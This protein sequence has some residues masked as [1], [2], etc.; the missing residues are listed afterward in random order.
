MWKGEKKKFFPPFY[1][2]PNMVIVST[3]TTH[4]RMMITNDKPTTQ[5]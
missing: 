1:V 3:H 5:I 2:P 4:E